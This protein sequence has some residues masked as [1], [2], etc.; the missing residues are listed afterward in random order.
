MRLDHVS[1]AVSNSEIAD[2]VQR[3][4]AEL[5]AAFV[6]GGRHPRFGTRNFILPLAGGRYL[7]VVS[8]LDHPAAESA[9][10]GRAVKA[11]ADLGG[12]WLG[13]VVSVDD[14][15]EVETRFGR[16]AVDGHR[17]RPDGF[18]LTWKQI[19]VNDLLHDPSVPYFVQWTVPDEQH[20]SCGASGA[21]GIVGCELAGDRER[22]RD[23]IGGPIESPVDTADIQWV[24]AEDPGLAA[25]LFR[26]PSGTV[27][28]D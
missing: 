8:A 22:I 7:E 18:D 14:I 4:G 13:W 24:D 23:A 5:G 2:T 11:R 17:V 15:A 3:L 9:P 20:P 6:D 26:T 16:T 27:R 12:G 21:V 19:G 25:V 10:F 28:I 1:Y